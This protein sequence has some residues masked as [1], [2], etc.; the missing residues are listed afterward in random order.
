MIMPLSNST[1]EE[2]NNFHQS[3]LSKIGSELVPNSLD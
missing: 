2:E 3:F 1:E